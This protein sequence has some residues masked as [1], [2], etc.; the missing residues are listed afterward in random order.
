MSG[1]RRESGMN[2]SKSSNRASTSQTQ[3]SSNGTT[4][5]SSSTC[6]CGCGCGCGCRE[7]TPA[8][9]CCKL[10]CF[11]RPKYFC[12][13]LLSDADLTLQETYFREKMKL[14]HRT[15]DGFGVVCGLRM[16]CDGDCK[17][18]ITIGDG[19]AIDCCG[20]DLVVCEPRKFDVI[21]E[22][23]KRN[24]LVDVPADCGQYRNPNED[25]GR[26][27]G[28]DERY[29]RDCI[30]KQC[31]YIGICY[32][33]EPLDFVAPYTTDCSPAPGP[34]QP[35]R[36]RECVSFEIYNKLPERPNPLDRIAERIECCFRIY[37][38]GQFSRGLVTL[39]PEILDVLGFEEY[40]GERRQERRDACELFLALQAQFLHE[41]RTCPD[42]YNCNIEEEVCRLRP[43]CRENEREGPSAFEA[44]TRL[45]ELI[46]KHVFTCVL[47]QF[48]FPCPEPSDPCCVLIGSVE[49]E[50]GKLTRVLNYPRWYLWCFVNFFE[51]LIYTL[52][53]DAAC[54]KPEKREGDDQQERRKGG[55]CPE[56]EVDI[57]KFLLLFAQDKRAAEL[58]GLASVNA[59]RSMSKALA[60]GFDFIKPGGI[61]GGVLEKLSPQ[62]ATRLA[63]VFG[64]SVERFAGPVQERSDPFTSVLS[65]LVFRERDHIALVEEEERVTAAMRAMKAP[66]S[67]VAKSDSISEEEANSIKRRIKQIEVDLGKLKSSLRKASDP[68]KE[69]GREHN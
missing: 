61:A 12:G 5:A 10:T 54:A 41:L 20:N 14:H 43:P 27:R 59:I 8:E 49:I 37:S 51:V 63:E 34:C 65:K 62:E 38:K 26:G 64:L 55:C 24:W 30:N 21:A 2:N 42:Q 4:V 66:S 45:F 52:A 56:F 53:N 46:Q 40:A 44:F 15:L 25:S 19:Y 47:A 9:G 1:A 60:S 67:A 58:S 17:G 36:I 23:R 13:Q 18:R 7:H 31:F 3:A 22:L 68:D 50:N 35:K 16:R 28:D 29:E 57:R 32:K 69:K 11:E 39:T 33:E 48:A 6:G